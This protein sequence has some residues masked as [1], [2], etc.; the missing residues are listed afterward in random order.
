MISHRER[1]V[2]DE[3]GQRVGVIL[4]MEEYEKIVEELEELESIRAFDDA[5]ALSDKSIPFEQAIIEIEQE[6][7]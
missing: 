7:Q 6:R 5:K 2:V 4:G 3:Q 1:Y